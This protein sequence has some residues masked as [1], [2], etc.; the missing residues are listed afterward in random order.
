MNASAAASRAESQS[1]RLRDRDSSAPRR[2]DC[3]TLNRDTLN[4]DTQPVTVT[5]KLKLGFGNF[6]LKYYLNAL[7]A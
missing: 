2:L 5:F 7:A 3:D 1:A 4:R 6:K